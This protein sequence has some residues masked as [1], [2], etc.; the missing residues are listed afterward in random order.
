MKKRL[1][2]FI[3]VLGIIALFIGITLINDTH[4]FKQANIFI[5]AAPEENSEMD[6]D[7][8]GIKD[9]LEP[10][11]ET[12]NG[13]NRD[14]LSTALTAT[15]TVPLT[16]GE[17]SIVHHI[18]EE[19]IKLYDTS[20]KNRHI[21]DSIEHITDIIQKKTIP[22]SVEVAIIVDE[23]AN[24]VEVLKLLNDLMKQRE[25]ILGADQEITVV[26]KILAQDEEARNVLDEIIDVY[27]QY[28]KKMKSTPVHPSIA[29]KYKKLIEKLIVVTQTLK[30]FLVNTADPI[31][32]LT[33]F[34]LFQQ[35][36]PGENKKETL[37]ALFES[38]HTSLILMNV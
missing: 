3:G 12:N 18:L 11:L 8:N 15:E 27:T 37:Y 4:D 2:I 14:V 25:E 31:V 26:S 16:F 38:L 29:E 9:W 7:N 32:L 21:E 20:A 19:S 28:S 10:L 34:T 1:Y 30:E 13:N 6:S 24:G 23:K 35:E 17:D 22:K 36:L 33:T 5:A